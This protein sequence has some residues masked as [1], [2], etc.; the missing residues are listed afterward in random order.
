MDRQQAR[1]PPAIPAGGQGEAFVSFPHS[2]LQ[3]LQAGAAQE[4]AAGPAAGALRGHAGRRTPCAFYPPWLR[5]H[6]LPT[7]HLPLEQALR[8][9]LPGSSEERSGVENLV[10]ELI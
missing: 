7:A 3:G 4:C 6:L 8:A 10:C 9:P 5:S 1:E 2:S